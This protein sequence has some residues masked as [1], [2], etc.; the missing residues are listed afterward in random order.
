MKENIEV[1][2]MTYFKKK[3]NS[4]KG[5]SII[6]ALMLFF[7]CFMVASVILSSATG[8]A[9][10]L[11]QRE[12]YQKEFLSVS[13]AA[14]LLQDIL[15]GVKYTG[16]ES[17]TVY[18]CYGELASIRPEKHH[19]RVDLCTEMAFDTGVEARVR[20]DLERM[21]YQAF[22]T[23][24]QYKTPANVADKEFEKDFLISGDGMED[25]KVHM[26]LDRNT[27]ML[28]C[29]LLLDGST[30]KSNAMTVVF[31]ASVSAPAKEFANKVVYADADTAH[32]IRVLVEEEDGTSSWK[33]ISKSYDIEVYTIETVVSYDDATITKGVSS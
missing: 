20:K 1:L 10:K 5:A 14:N 33:W 13:S 4:Q 3:L 24:T 16:W 32:E 28:T 25:V 2:S 7:V 9:D 27:Y 30:D 17:N 18:E 6:L 31:K 19:D 22:T 23:H 12:R 29:S 8:N 11:R 15:E 21:V 26:V